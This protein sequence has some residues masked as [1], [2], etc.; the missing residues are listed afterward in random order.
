MELLDSVST[1]K[2]ERRGAKAL[3]WGN[4]ALKIRKKGHSKDE[5][6]AN[7][8]SRLNRVSPRGDLVRKKRI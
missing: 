8:R 3:L 2:E 5:K 1:S 7:A 4:G 6:A